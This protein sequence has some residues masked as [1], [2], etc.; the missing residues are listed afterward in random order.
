MKAKGPPKIIFCVPKTFGSTRSPSVV[1]IEMNSNLFIKKERTLR[2]TENNWY[3]IWFVVGIS[4]FTS[5]CP[6]KSGV[7]GKAWFQY[8]SKYEQT[9]HKI[10]PNKWTFEDFNKAK[11]IGEKFLQTEQPTE[12]EIMSVLRS[13]DKRFQRVG[14]AAMSL[15]PIETDQLIDI[16]FEFIKDQDPELRWY[17]RYALMRFTQFPE[18]TRAER[19]KQLLE[20]IKSRP[21]KDLSFEEMLVL[22]KF[23]S[24]EAARFLTEQ[25]MKEGKENT[26]FRVCAFGS[27]KEM[28]NSYYDEAADYVKNNGSPEIKEELLERENYW[29]NRNAPTEKRE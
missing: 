10:S 24:K 1:K 22:G 25:L 6:Y 18:A 27:L 14:L 17:A 2:K 9:M 16:L 11:K 28:G 23:P 13:P 26:K 5:G 29:R 7:E 21:E 19:G 20:I 8:A 12:D 3:V 4:L 15:K